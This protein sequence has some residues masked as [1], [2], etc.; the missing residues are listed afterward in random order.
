MDADQWEC[1]GLMSIM[2]QITG[3]KSV[4]FEDTNLNLKMVHLTPYK[5]CKRYLFITSQISLKRLVQL[6]Q[7][8]NTRMF[9]L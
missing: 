8:L 6:V 1:V 5:R 2:T 3:N 4:S 9:K 7:V